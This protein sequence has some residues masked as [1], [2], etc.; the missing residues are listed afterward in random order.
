MIITDVR[1]YLIS[2]D[3]EQPF[4]FSTGVATHRSAAL[5]EI[6]TDEGIS[7]WGEA[8]CNGT[9]APQLAGSFIEFCFKPRLLGK[10]SFDIEVIWDDLYA[11]SRAFGQCGAGIYAL[12][13]IDIALWDILGKYLGQPIHRLIGGAF[14]EAVR[15]YATGFYRVAGGDYPMDAIREAEGHLARGFSAM[16]LKCGFGIDEDLAYIRAVRAAVGPG[17]TLMVDFNCC[18]NAA[19]ARRLILEL[20]E[21]KIHFI[22]EPLIT[23]DIEGYL[24]LRHLTPAYIAAGENI[25][26]KLGFR[27]WIAR[28]ALDILQ[29][30]LCACGGITEFRKIA[31]MAQAYT[32]MVMPHCWGTGIAL[33]ATLQALAALPFSPASLSAEAPMLEYDQ[34]AHP[35]RSD[36]IY[37]S[38]TRQGGM[39]AVPMAPGL[40]VEIDRRVIEKYLQKSFRT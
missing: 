11:F 7:G 15:P 19:Q 20:Q 2:A 1:T 4:H 22:E 3:L 30:D 31:G 32:T 13:A 21:S 26:T 6:V 14:R 27:H 12:S 18:Y 36:L 35:F 40:G 5:V 28:G 17:V 39:V 34:S 8:M 37:G 33:A 24:A 23:E 38:I 9:Q 25:F 29:P 10:S 16:K